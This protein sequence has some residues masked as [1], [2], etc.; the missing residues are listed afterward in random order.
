MGAADALDHPALVA[1]AGATGVALDHKYAGVAVDL[2]PDIDQLGTIA[3]RV[4]WLITVSLNLHAQLSVYRSM[5]F[6]F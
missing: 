2:H 3:A 5:Q 4:A 1:V 6:L